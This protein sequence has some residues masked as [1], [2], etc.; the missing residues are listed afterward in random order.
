MSTS[1]ETKRLSKSRVS[2]SGSLPGRTTAGIA[3][4][5]PLTSCVTL[6]LAAESVGLE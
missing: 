6:W 5:L 1:T 2:V 3:V 4:M